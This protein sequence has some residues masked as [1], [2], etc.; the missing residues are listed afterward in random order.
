VRAK[1][2][3]VLLA[4]TGI[5]VVAIQVLLYNW[6]NTVPHL[7]IFLFDFLEDD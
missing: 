6:P 1:I 3:S 4:L 7:D 5:A 2:P